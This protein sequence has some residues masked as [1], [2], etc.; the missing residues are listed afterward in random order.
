MEAVAVIGL[1]VFL[2]PLR[3]IC[4]VLAAFGTLLFYRQL[5]GKQFG[6]IT[7]DL[8]TTVG[9][10]IDADRDLARDAGYTF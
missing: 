10:T 9:S 3:C 5:A 6:G 1:L 4:M 7:G 2:S 8:L